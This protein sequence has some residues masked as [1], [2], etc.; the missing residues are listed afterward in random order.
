MVLQVIL[1]G[2]SN[3]MLLFLIA[4]GLSL[5]FG[6]MGVINFAHGAYFGLG[7]YVAVA[8]LTHIESFWLAILVVPP[9]IGLSAIPVE[10]LL[11]R[12]YDHNPIFQVLL[13][14]GI[15]IVIEESIIA[16]WGTGSKA[17]APPP[18]LA[19]FV[20]IGPI[21]YPKYRLFVILLGAATILGLVLLISYT[22]YG[23]IIRAGTLDDEMVEAAGIN[24]RRLFTAM[25]VGG[26]ALAGLAGIASAPITSVYPLMGE[27][28]L[29]QAFVVVVVGGI[30]NIR[31]PFFGAL[32]VGLVQSFTTYY[33]E[34]LSGVVIFLLMIV[35]LSVKPRGLFGSPD[36][37]DH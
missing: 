33:V 7:A 35:V 17:I 2:L 14:F 12:L 16:I 8:F 18:E 34:S 1:N 25:F 28:I 11:R 30:G 21:F 26:V 23:T 29:I 20:S 24:I 13:T 5:I 15:A 10:L 36:V 32:L 37:V 3:A 19:G 6:L 4:S 31:G 9:V 22:N 27:E